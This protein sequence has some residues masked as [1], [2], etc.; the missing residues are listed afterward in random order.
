VR[1][2][3]AEKSPSDSDIGWNRPILNQQNKSTNQQMNK[4]AKQDKVCGL[5]RFAGSLSFW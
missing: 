2:S 4:T 5:V 1:I 3:G